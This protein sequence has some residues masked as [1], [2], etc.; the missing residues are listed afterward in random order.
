MVSVTSL[1]YAGGVENSSR[2]R[3]Y[4]KFLLVAAAFMFPPIIFWLS[5]L[6]YAGFGI[7]HSLI[8]LLANLERDPSG[9]VFVVSIVIG[10]PLFALPLTVLGRWLAR[11][12]GAK[13]YRLG[14]LILAM[15]VIFL[16]VGIGGPLISW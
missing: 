11:V 1:W 2:T 7:E 10:C 4:N 12:Q 6:T 8:R 5:V 9:V 13:G 14:T 16:I 3:G 15:S